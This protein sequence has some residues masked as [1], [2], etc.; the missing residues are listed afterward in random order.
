MKL[1]VSQYEVH[2]PNESNTSEFMVKFKGPED[3]PYE[4]VSKKENSLIYAMLKW[5]RM[6][7]MSFTSSIILAIE[8]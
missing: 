1:L 7:E 8:C 4:G 6:W 2:L 3:S 5:L